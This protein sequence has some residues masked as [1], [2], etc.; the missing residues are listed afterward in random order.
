[1]KLK[2]TLAG[3]LA[4]KEKL[5]R[6]MRDIRRE[7]EDLRDDRRKLKLIYE[8]A[9]KRVDEEIA[10]LEEIQYKM[11]EDQNKITEAIAKKRA[12]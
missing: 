7:K 6:D 5:I 2:N 1:M 9:I 11:V 4:Q 12:S 3:L 8:T 10:G